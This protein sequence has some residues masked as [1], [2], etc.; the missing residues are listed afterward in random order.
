MRQKRTVKRLMTRELTPLSEEDYDAIEA[1]VME[2]ARGRWF[3]AEFASRNR[4][5]DT[6][7]LLDALEKLENVVTSQSAAPAAVTPVGDEVKYSIIEMADAISR[8]KTEIAAVRSDEPDESSIALAAGELG[9]IVTATEAATQGILEAA[10]QVQEVAWTMREQGAEE[11]HCEKLDALT[12]EIYMSCS[13][14]DITGQ[15]IS[16]VVS[17]L[18]FIEDRLGAMQKIW[19]IDAAPSGTGQDTEARPDTNLLNGPQLNGDGCSQDDI[20][21]MMVD[22]DG[23]RE[24]ASNATSEIAQPQPAAVTEVV[25][26][27]ETEDDDDDLLFHGVISDDAAGDI[28]TTLTYE[29]EE[30][31]ILEASP[32]QKREPPTIVMRKPGGI[33]TAVAMSEPDMADD[34]ADELNLQSLSQD[35]K[36]VLFS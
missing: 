25:R 20:D 5:A 9:A 2:T 30:E 34:V 22:V 24:A 27:D 36:L 17:L 33:A 8:T 12:T 1:A 6:R 3:L 35:E 16:K 21:L 26:A 19:G 4:T 15:R 7:V 11:T 18:S 13:F 29:P 14:Q 28:V 23:T 32:V 31:V 10:E